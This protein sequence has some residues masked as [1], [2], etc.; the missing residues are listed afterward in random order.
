V[1]DYQLMLDD[2]LDER[3]QFLLR[4]IVHDYVATAEPI[5]SQ[6]L[7]QRYQLQVKSATIRN[8]MLAMSD[9]GLLRQPHT[10]AGR[11]PS[12]RGY[13]FYVDRLMPALPPDADTEQQVGKLRQALHNEID[14]VLKQTCRMLTSLTHL[15]AVATPPEVQSLSLREIHVSPLDDRRC[16]LVVV[17]SNGEV[18]HRMIELADSLPAAELTRLSNRLTDLLHGMTVENLKGLLAAEG[19]NRIEGHFR[20]LLEAIRDLLAPP[21]SDDILVEGTRHM[22]QH[23]EFRDVNRLENLMEVLEERRSVLE[24]LQEAVNDTSVQV[25]IGEEISEEGLRDCSLVAARYSAGSEAYGAIGVIGPTRMAYSTTIP[26][27]RLVAQHL[28]D[29]FNRWSA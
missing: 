11:I 13:R 18:K 9:M 2:R 4:A 15:T 6:M 8:E 3:K 20:Q 12:D 21:Q 1:E 22:L 23:P 29:F 17:S 27:V 7:V 5:A 24:L 19:E 14:E 26:T 10:S 28:S 16:L 25:V